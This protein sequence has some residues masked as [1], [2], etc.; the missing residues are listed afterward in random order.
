MGAPITYTRNG[1]RVTLDMPCEDYQRL[2]MM[3]GYVA[4]QEHAKGEMPRFW[5][6]IDLTN[7]MNATNPNFTPY[8]IPPGK[9]PTV[10]KPK[11][12]EK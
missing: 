10:G 7:R 3:L 11:T 4:G 8:E 1:D 9:I 12:G 5:G 6:W 2:L